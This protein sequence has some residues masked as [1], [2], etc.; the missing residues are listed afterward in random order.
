MRQRALNPWLLAVAAT[1]AVYPFLVYLSL[2]DSAASFLR[3]SWLVVVALILIGLRLLA[4]RDT[5]GRGWQIGSA[6]A[7]LALMA[8]LALDPD[9]AAKAYPVMI[10]LAAAGIFGSSLLWPP[11]V[12]ERIA[13]LREPDLSPQA[14]AYTRGVTRIWFWFL[15]I[16]ATIAAALG[17]WGS[18]A[19]WTLWTGLISYLLMGALFLGELGWR[20]YIGSRA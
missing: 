15:L 6:G 3:P 13:R 14:V 1:G 20:H 4:M 8:L 10:G 16:N 12:V 2:A 7:A 5:V 19:Q 18:L 9:L 17:L 11:T